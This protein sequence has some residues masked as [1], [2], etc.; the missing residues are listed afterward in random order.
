MPTTTPRIEVLSGSPLAGDS[1]AEARIEAARGNRRRLRIFLT[2]LAVSLVI[3]LAYTF[4][5]PAVYRS[6]ATLLIAPPAAFDKETAETKAQYVAV[7][8]QRL[9][10]LELLTE[11]YQRLPREDFPG[12]RFP[13]NPVTLRQMLS[14]EPL[15]ETHMVELRAEGGDKLLL[16]VLVN[17]WVDTYVESHRGGQRLESESTVQA[18]REQAADLERRVADKRLALDE[19]R[20]QYDIVSMERDENQVLARLKGLSDSLKKANEAVVSAESRLTALRQAAAQGKTVVS[21]QY[22]GELSRLEDRASELR[23]RLEA[24][25]RRFTQAYMELDPNIVAMTED[26]ERTQT[27][28]EHI[29]RLGERE[30]LEA[31]EQQVAGARDAV[32]R[33][34]AQLTDYKQT[35][36]DFTTRFGEHDALQREL[37]QLEA[38]YQDVQERLVDEEVS[39]RYRFP[40][41][42]VLDKGYM[43]DWPIH[44]DYFRDAGLSLVGS[45]LMGL[46]AVA[47]H[48]LFDR[49]PRDGGPSHMV[50]AIYPVSG[51]ETLAHDEPAGPHLD[52]PA[53]GPALAHER[54]RELAPAEAQALLAVAGGPGRRLVL[55]LL[56][57]LRIQEAPALRWEHV[58]LDARCLHV[59]GAQGRS[60]PL[61]PSLHRELAAAGP[62]APDTPLWSDEQGRPLGEDELRGLIAC[63][64][65]DAGLHQPEQVTPEALFH[66]YLAYLVRQGLRLGE[67]ERVAGPIPPSVLAGYGA[68]SPN[69]PRLTL[70]EI[71]PIYPLADNQEQG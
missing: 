20:R 23:G 15:P 41:V 21:D 3:S 45:L 1:R 68:Y 4:L 67:L 40:Q 22:R 17:T 5:R 65:Y 71:D 30:A 70:E 39:N 14:V 25:S 19:F 60:L 35:A 26:L 9:T 57:G 62:A 31:A 52:A 47:L 56:G 33:L 53:T 7:Q 10:S 55:G 59:P 58:H 36:R 54:S 28:I 42:T 29:R 2:V 46:L 11:V 38:L 37:Q 32:R 50:T 34:E 49:P 51:R 43:P 16:P 48:S 66:T 13:A 44:P 12:D 8:Q 27:R 63:L 64:A 18:L 61:A 24:L 69:G 6:T